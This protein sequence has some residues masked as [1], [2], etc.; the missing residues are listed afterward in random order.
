MGALIPEKP[1]GPGDGAN[2]DNLRHLEF[3]RCTQSSISLAAKVALLNTRSVSNK[4]FLLNDFF[5]R[6]RLDLLFLT[7]TWLGAAA[8]EKSVFGELC[9]TNCSFL[10]TPRSSWRGDGVAL[11][12][13]TLSHLITL[14][15]RLLVLGDFNIHVCCPDGQGQGILSCVG[16]SWLYATY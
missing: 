16:F 13:R 15:D 5:T 2:G 3:V 8:G 12:F 1:T 9:P 10:C 6:R 7:E 11:V 14:H 4:T